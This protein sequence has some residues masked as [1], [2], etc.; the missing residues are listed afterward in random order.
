MHTCM[1]ECARACALVTRWLQVVPRYALL[2]LGRDNWLA[3][4][5]A[6]NKTAE[7]V[8]A[9]AQPQLLDTPENITKGEASAARR[10][11]PHVLHAVHA[12][13][14]LTHMQCMLPKAT[15]R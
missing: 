13:C 11:S 8:R 15:P 1:H 7:E 9:A 5:I 12:T 3:R 6:G 10:M 14:Q 4:F 2:E